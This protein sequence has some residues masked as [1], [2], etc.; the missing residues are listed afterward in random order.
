MNISLQLSWQGGVGASRLQWQPDRSAPSIFA[1]LESRRLFGEDQRCRRAVDVCASCVRVRVRVHLALRGSSGISERW[2]CCFVIEDLSSSSSS[3]IILPLR[4]VRRSACCI[5]MRSRPRSLCLCLSQ[6]TW[7]SWRFSCFFQPEAA[8]YRRL[9]S[10]F[11]PEE[12]GT[13]QVSGKIRP[14]LRMRCCCFASSG[15]P[16]V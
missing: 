3:S 12:S 13:S 15:S 8:A 4:H 11:E 5:L 14:I 9:M 16:T 2:R 6:P 7:I 1:L 10:M